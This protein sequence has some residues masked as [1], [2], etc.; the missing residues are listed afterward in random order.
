MIDRS[1]GDLHPASKPLRLVLLVAKDEF[2]QGPP[3]LGWVLMRSF[4]KALAG[5]ETK[6]ERAIFVN[7]GVRLT[8]EGSVVLSDVKALENAGVEI[9]SCATCLDYFDLKEK[10][11][12][13]KV[14]NMS[15][16]VAALMR[17]D[18]VVSL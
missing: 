14:T 4:L 15:D 1:V 8:T 9:L 11:S 7:T 18:R 17:A 2:G 10:L 12:V 6:P 13:G 5:S 16:T 3:E